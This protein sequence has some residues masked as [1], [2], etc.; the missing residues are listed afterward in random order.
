MDSGDGM[1]SRI[2]VSMGMGG[3]RIVGIITS[4]SI[5]VEGLM[6]LEMGKVD[7]A[8]LDWD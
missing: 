4:Y 5:R 3:L 6:V 2:G 1:R 8:C 7:G